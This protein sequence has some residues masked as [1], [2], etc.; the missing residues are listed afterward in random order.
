MV[1]V[2]LESHVT[3]GYRRRAGGTKGRRLRRAYG[4]GRLRYVPLIMMR[5]ELMTANRVA[6]LEHHDEE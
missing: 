4:F 1:A 2:R 5:S 6:T 3:V